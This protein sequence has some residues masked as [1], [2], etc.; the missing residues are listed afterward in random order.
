MQLRFMAFILT[1]MPAFAIADT[2]SFE[3][4]FSDTAFTGAIECSKFLSNGDYILQAANEETKLELSSKTPVVSI[5]A[6]GG[7][8]C[9]CYVPFIAE[10]AYSEKQHSYQVTTPKHDK[11]WVT[12]PVALSETKSMIALATET[13]K[14]EISFRTPAPFIDGDPSLKTPP[15]PVTLMQIPPSIKA[16][17]TAEKKDISVVFTKRG[18]VTMNNKTYVKLRQDA[19]YD[20]DYGC[21]DALK[22]SEVKTVYIRDIIVDAFDAQ[23]RINLWLSQRPPC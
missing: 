7:G 11:I 21:N 5:C 9:D 22:E 1:L 10:K 16:Q 6:Q 14:G 3:T 12:I 4:I 19:V 8:D 15:T 20:L 23:G 13:E 17:F 2:I 18:I